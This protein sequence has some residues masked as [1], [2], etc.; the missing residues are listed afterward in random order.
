[1]GVEIDGAASVAPPDVT[2]D[3][4]TAAPSA[5]ST[6]PATG[7]R[8]PSY[9]ANVPAHRHVHHLYRFHFQEPRRERMFLA[10]VGFIL[11]FAAVRFIVTSIRAGQGPF[12]NV[13]AG[14]MHIH[15]L[16]WGILLLLLVGYIWLAQIGTGVDHARRWMRVTAILFGIGAALTLDEFALWLNLQDVYWSRA[17][18]ASVRAVLLFGAVLSTGVWGGA[19]LRALAHFLVRHTHMHLRRRL[20]ALRRRVI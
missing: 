9:D 2:N 17:G 8:P 6:E 4:A 7:V 1:M 18:G 16:V 3:S 10:S 20:R 11:T 12:H 13:S 5:L 14:G 15:H 19:F